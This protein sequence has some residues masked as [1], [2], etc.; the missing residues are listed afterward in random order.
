[1]HHSFYTPSTDLSLPRNG[2]ITSF[3]NTQNLPTSIS[4]TV[5]ISPVLHDA[6]ASDDSAK[7]SMKEPE[8]HS[9]WGSHNPFRALVVSSAP[10]PLHHDVF[11]QRFE[12]RRL[13][14]VGSPLIG[15]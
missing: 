5:S 2:T 7:D 8:P 11:E 3:E 12:H 15:V 13:E 6:K 14:Q 10:S 1:M 4:T 9:H